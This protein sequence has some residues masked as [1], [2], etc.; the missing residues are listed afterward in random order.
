MIA[1]SKTVMIEDFMMMMMMMM[2]WGVYWWCEDFGS[3]LSS[4]GLL[5]LALDQSSATSKALIG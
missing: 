5:Q 1:A 2:M 3:V 4:V